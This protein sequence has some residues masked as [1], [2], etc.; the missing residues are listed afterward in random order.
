MSFK[1]SALSS[2]DSVIT[3]SIIYQYRTRGGR[4][5]DVLS[6][7]SCSLERSSQVRFLASALA[8]RIDR[9]RCLDSSNPILIDLRGLIARF[10]DTSVTNHLPAEKNVNFRVPEDLRESFY[11]AV[12]SQDKNASQVFR[13]FMR[14]YV[15]QHG[16]GKLL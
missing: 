6:V 8:Y 10:G 13:E 12:A 1:F 15:A 2:V 5:V 9:R 14:K 16:Q 7:L 11:A 3:K 4:Y